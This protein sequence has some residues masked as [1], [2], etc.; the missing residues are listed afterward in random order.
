MVAILQT[1][2]W[3]AFSWMK[4]YEFQ[5]KF[6]WSWFVRVQLT[7]YQHWFR[8]WLGAGQATSHCLN[9]WR[10]DYR[11]IYASFG[12]NAFMCFEP[13]LLDGIIFDG[14][15]CNWFQLAGVL[16]LFIHSFS[17]NVLPLCPSF[18]NGG[19]DLSH[20]PLCTPMKYYEYSGYI[21]CS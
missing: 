4:M 15:L 9:Q 3:N 16:R 21:V 12:L 20:T 18:G 2:F 17:F 1:T 7:I 19:L 8:K 11:R 5:L 14:R 10:L 6:H 13:Y